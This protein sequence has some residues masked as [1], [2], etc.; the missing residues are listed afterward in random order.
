MGARTATRNEDNHVIRTTPPGSGLAQLCG[1]HVEEFGL[2]PPPDGKGLASQMIRAQGVM[3]LPNR[4]SE[5]SRREHFI[6]LG[7]KRVRAAYCYELLTPAGDTE[8]I[9]KWDARFIAQTPAVT[10]RKFGRGRAIYVGTYFTPELSEL[11]LPEVFSKAN[12]QPLVHD[13]PEGVEV[14]LREGQGQRLL[15]LQNTLGNSAVVP[16]VPAGTELLEETK[17]AGG[18][19]QLGPYGCAVVGLK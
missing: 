18:E 6:R 3:Q 2:L 5:S 17:H 15:F 7:D 14:S 4:P 10:A 1:V 12:V 13:L 11:L 9:A 16:A 8:V 19:M